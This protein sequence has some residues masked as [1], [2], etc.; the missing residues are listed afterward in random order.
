MDRETIFRVGS[1]HPDPVLPQLDWLR[2]AYGTLLCPKC[3]C[4]CRYRAPEPFNVCLTRHPGNRV[5]SIMFR[6]GIGLYHTELFQAIHARLTQCVVGAFQMP[7]GSTIADYVTF[8]GSNYLVAR[9]ERN[10]R[11]YRCTVCGSLNLDTQGPQPQCILRADLS[12]NGV[13]QCAGGA[14]YISGVVA[15]EIDWSRWPDARLDPVVILDG[16]P[17]DSTVVTW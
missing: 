13:Y 4:I 1:T 3:K 16:P 8:Y 11:L 2:R 17:K 9:R 5:E 6:A 10:E 7:D 14:L 12:T 15:R